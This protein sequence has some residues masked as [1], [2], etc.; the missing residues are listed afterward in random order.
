MIRYR[1][2]ERSPEG[3]HNEWKYATSGDE[4]WGDPLESTRDLGGER[5][6]GLKRRDLR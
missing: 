3:Q 5:L 1:S 2:V 4:R 6:S